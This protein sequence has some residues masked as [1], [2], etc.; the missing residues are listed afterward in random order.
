MR[1][2]TSRGVACESAIQ[3]VAYLGVRSLRK[4]PGTSAGCRSRCGAK[5]DWPSVGVI[6]HASASSEFL[7]PPLTLAMIDEINAVK[8]IS[9]TAGVHPRFAESGRESGYRGLR[10]VVST[11]STPWSIGCT[12]S[13][14]MIQWDDE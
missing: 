8:E 10:K 5:P 14:M 1:A 11:Q 13:G 6:D 3:Q 7:Q 12:I 4:E 2:A 9:W